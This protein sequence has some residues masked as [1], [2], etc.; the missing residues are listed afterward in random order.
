MSQNIF[1][2][3]TY[4]FE[5][6][7]NRIQDMFYERLNKF[8]NKN[9]KNPE[10]YNDKFLKRISDSHA[11]CIYSDVME[12]PG[13]DEFLKSMELDVAFVKSKEYKKGLKKDF[14][15]LVYKPKADWNLN[16][17]FK[18][19]PYFSCIFYGSKMFAI[20]PRSERED[21]LKNGLKP[22][23]DFR[24]KTHP[25]F[26][27][28]DERTYLIVKMITD[29]LETGSLDIKG[30]INDMMKQLY[31]RYGEDELDVW[32]VNLPVYI[33]LKKDASFRYG[34]YA[35]STIKPVSIKLVDMDNFPMYEFK[36]YSKIRIELGDDE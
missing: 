11:F 10:D 29:N 33:E 4:P 30:V 34:G 17:F 9:G 22:R 13:I 1:E 21:I 3:T 26:E 20:R 27:F 36:K 6:A 12:I 14:V 15:V 7:K 2:I 25:G 32:E 23:K 35:S 5:Y 8:L 31:D 19:F 28:D 16:Q 24:L 18:L